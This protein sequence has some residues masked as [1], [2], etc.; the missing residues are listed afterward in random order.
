M[1]CALNTGFAPCLQT[2]LALSMTIR[3][4]SSSL[5]VIVYNIVHLSSIF[6]VVFILLSNTNNTS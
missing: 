6:L 2:K 3:Y 5:K 4:I 1:H